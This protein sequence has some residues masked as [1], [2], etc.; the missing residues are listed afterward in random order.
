MCR[1][2]RLYL[3]QMRST[4]LAVGALPREP[5]PSELREEMLQRFRDWKK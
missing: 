5:I 3:R 1:H 2:C 4:V